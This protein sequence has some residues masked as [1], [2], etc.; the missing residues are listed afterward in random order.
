LQLRVER[1]EHRRSGFDKHHPGLRADVDPAKLAWQHRFRQLGDL[2]SQLHPGRSRADDDEREECR[3]LL[4]IGNCL[5]H[6]KR[7][8]DAAAQPPGILECLHAWGE[9]GPLVVP[10]VGVRGAARDDQRVVAALQ[11]AAIG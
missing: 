8:Q 3:S 7:R 5:G 6:L 2:P 4:G 10:E 1:S 9:R 11:R